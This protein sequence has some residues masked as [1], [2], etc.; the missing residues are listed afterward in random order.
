MKVERETFGPMLRAARQ[1]RGVTLEELAADTKLG[2]ELWADLEEND[3]SRWPRRIYARS[4]IRDY[5]LK[6]GLEPDEVVNEFCRLFPEW[7]DRR[8]ERLIR[9]QAAIINHDLAW[10]EPVKSQQRRA[11]DAS[12]TA[13]AFVAKHRTRIVAA[14]IDLAAIGGATGVAGLLRLPIWTSLAVIAVGYT[15]AGTLLS[16]R[17]FGWAAAEWVERVVLLSEHHNPVRVRPL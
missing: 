9:G 5:A 14:A 4:Y 10:E 11:S 3:L 13:P 1:R 17:G 6:A 12:M 16:D 8:A 15:V 7:G 2:V